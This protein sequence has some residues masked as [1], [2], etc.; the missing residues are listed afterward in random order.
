MALRTPVYNMPIIKNH[1]QTNTIPSSPRKIFSLN[2][3]E[4]KV[5]T[6]GLFQLQGTCRMKF[7]VLAPDHNS[8]PRSVIF[9]IY[10]FPIIVREVNWVKSW[11]KEM[12]NGKKLFKHNN[13]KRTTRKPSARI[14]SSGTRL[15]LS[16]G[17]KV[18]SILGMFQVQSGT[19]LCK[20]FITL[21]AY[22]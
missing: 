11:Q 5:P 18:L 17:G 13:A 9:T 12:K 6:V 3:K 21:I 14:W 16:T 7:S 19:S 15:F 10:L 20:F 1:K 4:N 22:S 2:E 8:E